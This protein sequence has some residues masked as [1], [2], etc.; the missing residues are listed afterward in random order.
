[1]TTSSKEA[2]SSSHTLRRALF[3][4]GFVGANFYYLH[5]SLRVCVF[6]GCLIPSFLLLYGYTTN[7]HTLNVPNALYIL[8]NVVFFGTSFLYLPVN[9][10]IC[11][12]L[13]CLITSFFFLLYTT[14][15]LLVTGAGILVMTIVTIPDVLLVVLPVILHVAL[16]GILVFIPIQGATIVG[17]PCTFKPIKWLYDLLISFTL[18]ARKDGVGTKQ[19]NA[20]NARTVTPT[21]KKIQ[22]SRKSN[23]RASSG[24]GSDEKLNQGVEESVEGCTIGK[25]F[26]SSREI[27][28]GSNGTIVLEGTYEG[29]PVAVKRL[30]KAYHDVASKEHRNLSVS[31]S[32]PNIV[33]LYGKESDRDFM[34]LALERCTCNLNDFIQ[35]PTF[36][37]DQAS[38]G[39]LREVKLWTEE[40]YPS[41]I[42]FKLMRDVVSGLVHLHELGMVHRDLKPQNVLIIE[43][44]CLCAKLS[45]MGISKR[46]MEDK[47]S[48]GN[49]ATGNPIAQSLISLAVTGCGSSGWQAPEQLLNQ[50]QTLAVDMF[51]LG[52]VLFYC[53]TGGRHPFGDRLERDINIVKSKAD[54]FLVEDIPEAVDLLSCLLD[55]DAE[56]RPKASEV[57]THPMFWNS[58]MRLSFLRDASDR[59]EREGRGSAILKA[60]QSIAP[61]VLDTKPASKRNKKTVLLK[62]D[63]KI[64]P[65]LL[66]DSRNHRSYNYESVRDLL[67]L[68]RN[69][70]NHIFDLPLEVQEILGPVPE[71]FDGYFRSQFPKLLIEVYK[72]MHKCCRE[73][74][75]FSKYFKGS[76]DCVV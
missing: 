24:V 54:L 59:V 50:R 16:T 13:G 70:Q 40:G 33:R 14:K 67:R 48:L 61:L 20:L 19:P 68:T 18:N 26:V 27:A 25:L 46:L 57:L 21:G 56:S 3:F 69:K 75:W 65:A 4:F 42:L 37:E 23:G 35:K 6:L 43:G 55:R 60:L 52:C 32:H 63:K 53:I 74:E 9:F 34:Y 66:N 5:V 15:S 29:R 47:S 45:D 58:E 41:P 38:E 30:V 62:W 1:M 36:S 8:L 12:F 10:T 51:S 11:I 44:R 49:H 71:G 76:V 73:E 22:R 17:L 7:S 28:T 64:E 31:D 39:T 2:S 72:V